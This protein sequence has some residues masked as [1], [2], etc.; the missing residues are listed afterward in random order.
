MRR[1][2]PP[3]PH[4]PHQP[5]PALRSRQIALL[6]AA[7]LRQCCSCQLQ[8]SRLDNKVVRGGFLG[9]LGASDSAWGVRGRALY[10]AGECALSCMDRVLM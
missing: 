2:A 9:L 6:L 1:G 5:C 8:R 10:I 3:P 4:T 7:A